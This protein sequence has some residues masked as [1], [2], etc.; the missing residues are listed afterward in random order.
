MGLFFYSFFWLR[1]EGNG[2]KIK[3][4]HLSL[5]LFFPIVWY[6]A[7]GQLYFKGSCFYLATNPSH[8]FYGLIA[9]LNRSRTLVCFI[10]IPDFNFN[11][12]KIVKEK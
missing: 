11:L 8:D 4:A 10:S 7:K 9:F 2:V 1:R 3:T 5:I 12:K 6:F